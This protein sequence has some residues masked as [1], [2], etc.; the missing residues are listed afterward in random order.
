[1]FSC[2]G[3]GGL[4]MGFAMFQGGGLCCALYHVLLLVHMLMFVFVSVLLLVLPGL[5]IC[6]RALFF[7][8]RYAITTLRNIAQRGDNLPALLAAPPVAA[9]TFVDLL[10]VL[11]IRAHTC[12]ISCP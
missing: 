9:D 6:L 4:P 8:V 5:Y 11:F 12:S 10:Q 2:E 3:V 1:M 7:Y